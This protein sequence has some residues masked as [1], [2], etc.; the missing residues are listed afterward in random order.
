MN[1]EEA[2]EQFGR[3]IQRCYRV[4]RRLLLE[5]TCG[6]VKVELS[7]A[8][9]TKDDTMFHFDD[10]STRIDLMTARRLNDSSSIAKPPGHGFRRRP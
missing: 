7:T 6:W 2:R 9:I 10:F 4:L 5:R 1:V 3:R 8:R